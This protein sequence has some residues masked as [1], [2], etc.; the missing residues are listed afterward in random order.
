MSKTKKSAKSQVMVTVTLSV[1]YTHPSTPPKGP[2]A[3]ALHA[4]LESAICRGLLT[5]GQAHLVVDGYSLEA[6]E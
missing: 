3:R 1:A 5:E 2:T 4:S 6:S